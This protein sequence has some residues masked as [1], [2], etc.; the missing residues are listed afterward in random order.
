MNIIHICNLFLSENKLQSERSSLWMADE[1]L[2]MS[3]SAHSRQVAK[4]N[5]V[6]LEKEISV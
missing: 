4:A 1:K 6:R 5:L 2:H 3:L